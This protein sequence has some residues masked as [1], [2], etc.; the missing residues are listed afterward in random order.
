MKRYAKM[1]GVTCAAAFA[2]VAM[3][4]AGASAARFTASETGTLT[5]IST[6]NHVFT[7]GGGGSI[8]CKKTHTSGMIVSREAASQHLTVK[9]SECTAS[10]LPAT[11][12]PATLEVYANGTMDIEN[13]IT[14]GYFGCTTTI[15]PQKG[16]KTINYTNSAGKLIL[17][18]AVGGIVSTASAHLC[19]GGTTG[20]TS[21]S[22]VLERVGGGTLTWH[23]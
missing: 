21:G 10:S 8:T 18:F 1:L 19:S 14:I 20:T 12:S 9:Y 2:L 6:T 17:H 3:T 11:V 13:T 7:T 16:L 4:A 15:K 23:P 22:F 5:G